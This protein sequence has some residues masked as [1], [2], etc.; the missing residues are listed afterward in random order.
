MKSVTTTLLFL[1]CLASV[2]CASV[3]YDSKIKP[4]GNWYPINAEYQSMTEEE[5]TGLGKLKK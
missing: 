3:S 1:L 4:T 2:G 5:R